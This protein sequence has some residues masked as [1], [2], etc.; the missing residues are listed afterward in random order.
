MQ[1]SVIIIGIIIVV[2]IAAY[3]ILDSK[4][5]KNVEPQN[6]ELNGHTDLNSALDYNINRN[7]LYFK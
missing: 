6:S 2:A 7:L 1:K 3:A 4:S 5:Q